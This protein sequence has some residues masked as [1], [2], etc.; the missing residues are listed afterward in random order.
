LV[1]GPRGTK[2]SAAY[3][4]I[5]HKKTAIIE[6]AEAAGLELLPKKKRNPLVSTT[7]GVGELML[8]ALEKG[9]KRIILGIG[10][11]AT[12]DCGAGALSAL[13]F[14]FINKAGNDI[15]PN[16]RGLLSLDSVDDAHLDKKLRKVKI[17]VAS[18][19]ENVLTGAR[20]ALV[21][22]RQK[23]ATER[24]LPVIGSAL[25]NFKKVISKQ[26]GI[27]VDRISGSG[28]AGGIGG[29]MKVLLNAEIRSGFDI[30]QDAVSLE[31][32][33]KQSDIVITGEGVIDEQTFYGKV[34]QKVLDIAYKH[35]KP[36]I[37]IAGRITVDTRIFRKSGAVGFYC[38][39]K[40]GMSVRSAIQN[41]PRLL[42]NVAFSIGK[43]LRDQATI[44]G[45]KSQHLT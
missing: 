5:P 35:K 7:K 43:K 2:V 18:D 6:L 36:V 45:V 11:S 29:A 37:F 9:H 25:K 23:G 30:V 16:C 24:M 42:E 14:R 19:V 3:G 33:I 8:N 1:T 21:Y 34:P 10:D 44:Y 38:I 32:K 39:A 12:I 31:D 4:V 22:A 26:Y 41:T 13:G 27:D 20:G 40:R 17:I 28:A 15:E